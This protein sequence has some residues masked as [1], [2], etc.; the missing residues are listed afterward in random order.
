MSCKTSYPLDEVSSCSYGFE[1]NLF[2][3]TELFKE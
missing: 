3:I 2:S 1:N